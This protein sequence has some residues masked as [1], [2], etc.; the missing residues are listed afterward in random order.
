MSSTRDFLLGGSSS[1]GGISGS[2]NIGA[3]EVAAKN[4]T[5]SKASKL[6]RASLRCLDFDLG[7]GGGFVFSE[8]IKN[9]QKLDLVSE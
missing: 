7:R 3:G 2:S 1:T 9:E 4:S 8:N 6:A 5:F